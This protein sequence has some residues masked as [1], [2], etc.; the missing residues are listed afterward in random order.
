MSD[1]ITAFQGIRII[2]E[3]EAN[4]DHTDLDN[5]ITQQIHQNLK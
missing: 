5:E 3:N 2:F 1:L 4:F